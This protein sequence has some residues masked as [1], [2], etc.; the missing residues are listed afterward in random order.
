MAESAA[1]KAF[2]RITVGL[3]FLAT[4]AISSYVPSRA[5]AGPDRPREPEAPLPVD[6]RPDRPG[7]DARLIRTSP[8]VVGRLGAPRTYQPSFPIRAAFFYPW[9]P[10]AWDQQG[11]YPYSHFKPAYGYYASDEGSVIDEQLRRARRAGLEA[12]IASWWGPGHHTDEAIQ[13]IMSRSERDGSPYVR[14]RWAI[15]YER[16]GQGDPTSQQIAADLRYLAKNLFGHRSYLRVDDRP[17]VFVWADPRDGTAM[18]ERWAQARK[19]FGGDVYINL[20]V[21]SG[22]QADSARADSWHQYGPALAYE[23]HRPYSVTVSPGFWKVGEQPRLGRDLARFRRDVARMA[24]SGAQ[25]QLITTWN[26]WGEGTGIEPTRE[27]GAG[28]VEAL[29]PAL[30]GAG[31]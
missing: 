11:V 16:E 15:Y 7:L 30:D 1:G 20:K 2:L 5:S 10:A 25:W 24:A 6:D 26:E 29:C 31:C 9:F 4:V 21:Y 8:R 23:D 3:A 19:L 13:R 27:F 14:L 12:M 18:A 22:Y 28:Y 17:V